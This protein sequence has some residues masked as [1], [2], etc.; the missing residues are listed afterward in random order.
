MQQIQL[1]WDQQLADGKQ[2]HQSEGVVLFPEQLLN[3]MA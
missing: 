3:N 2:T 1:N